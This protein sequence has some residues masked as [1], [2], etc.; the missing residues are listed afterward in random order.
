M[1]SGLRHLSLLGVDLLSGRAGVAAALLD[2]ARGLN[3]PD[4]AALA[5]EAM[6]G[7]ARILLQA[8]P[9]T[10]LIFGAGHVVGTGGAV[11]VL[12]GDPEL[13][14]LAGEVWRRLTDLRIW[15]WSGGDYVSGLDGWKAASRALGGAEPTEHGPDRPYAPCALPRLAPWLDPGNAVPLCA[16][17]AAA[18]RLH[19]DRGMHGS[20]FADRWL[21]DRHDLSGVDGLPALAVRFVELASG[22]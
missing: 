4:L 16:D 11:S 15:M 10:I 20:W 12:A 18:T 3:R 5:R 6:Q 19:R 1:H 7:V 13:R 2:L 8:Q 14:P 9:E 17:R 22:H 21:D